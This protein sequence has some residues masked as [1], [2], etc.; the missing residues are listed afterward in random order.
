MAPINID[1]TTAIGI[2]F[3]LSQHQIQQ[4]MLQFKKVALNK[5]HLKCIL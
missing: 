3:P 5:R 2:N 4:L 1:S